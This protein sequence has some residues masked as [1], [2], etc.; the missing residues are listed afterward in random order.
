[1]GEEDFTFLLSR[2]PEIADAVN[3]FESEELQRE[4]FHALVGAFRGQPS[5]HVQNETRGEE[6]PSAEH[7]DRP[8]RKRSK[9]GGYSPKLVRDLNLSPNGKKPFAE[10][11]TEKQPQSNEDKYAVVVYYLEQVLGLKEIT[12]DHVSSVFRLTNGWKEPGNIRSGITTAASR[13]GTIDTT[14]FD[15]LKTTPHGRNFVDHDLPK[16]VA[17]K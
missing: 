14:D 15:D 8:R 9:G 1:M 13:K 16:K 6:A 7:K 2:M 11:V 10:F 17:K 12:L 5:N 4:A 3:A